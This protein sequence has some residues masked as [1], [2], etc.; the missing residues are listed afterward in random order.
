MEQN[1]KTRVGRVVSDKMEK[2]V[3]VAVQGMRKHELYKKQM[4][5]TK[6]FLAHDEGSRARLGD[7]VRIV[8]S[9]PMSKLKHWRVLDILE[10][11]QV[12]SLAD[13]V[14]EA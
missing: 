5:R 4:R 14:V 3:V 9:R 12:V 13:E 11:K 7:L 6:K 10:H 2:T 1:R 8:E